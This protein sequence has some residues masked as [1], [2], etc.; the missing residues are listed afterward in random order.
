MA[1]PWPLRK[2]DMPVGREI[3]SFMCKFRS[4]CDAG[5]QASLNFNP[6]NG[7]AHL[8]LTVNLG[9]AV[10]ETLFNQY[11]ASSSPIHVFFIRKCKLGFSLTS[12]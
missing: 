10:N 3:N 7:Q 5:Y 8:S 11:Q 6:I 2:H 4:L 9:C 1:G 12:F